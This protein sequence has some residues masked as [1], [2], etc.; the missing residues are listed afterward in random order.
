MR[1]NYFCSEPWGGERFWKIKEVIWVSKI[2]LSKDRK[3]NIREYVDDEE[4]DFKYPNKIDEF[5]DLLEYF[6]DKKH[7]AMK[8]I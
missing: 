8:V 5:D 1:E 2:P 7:R 4:M 3:N 6:K